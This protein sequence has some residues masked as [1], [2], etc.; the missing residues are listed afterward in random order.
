M[1]SD[2]KSKNFFWPSITNPTEAAAASA[3]GYVAALIVAGITAVIAAIAVGTGS[4]IA[5]IN[6]WSFVDSLLLGIIAWRIKKGS[7]VFALAGLALF[8]VEKVYQFSDPG[9]RSVGAI[10]AVFLLLFFISGVRGNFAL[11]KFKQ[12]PGI[13]PDTTST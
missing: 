9:G 1:T 12:E 5:S 6:A 4:D 8:I 13:L 10:M 11:H 2:A 3:Q 7:R